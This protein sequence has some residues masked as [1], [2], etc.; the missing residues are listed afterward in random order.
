MLL[1]HWLFLVFCWKNVCTIPYFFYLVD[2]NLCIL[3]LIYKY[4]IL[5]HTTYI[6]L[7]Q[8]LGPLDFL[9]PIFIPLNVLLFKLI[10]IL[11]LRGFIYS[12]SLKILL[13]IDIT[14]FSDCCWFFIWLSLF[15]GQILC[16]LLYFWWFTHFFDFKS[17]FLVMLVVW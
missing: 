13:L 17:F 4:L 16:L 11:A 8:Y 14:S 15:C 1:F 12:N 2:F 10:E 3:F 5:Y 7:K 6:D 9:S